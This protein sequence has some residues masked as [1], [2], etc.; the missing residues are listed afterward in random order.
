VGIG[1]NTRK[2]GKERQRCVALYIMSCYKWFKVVLITKDS[3]HVA[4]VTCIDP[5]TGVHGF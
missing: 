4:L 2:G 5:K 1:G 3:N